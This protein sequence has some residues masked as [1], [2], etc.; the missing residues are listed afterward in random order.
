MDTVFHFFL[1]SSLILAPSAATVGQD[2]PDQQEERMRVEGHVQKKYI[3]KL[4]APQQKQYCQA[5]S[6][7]EYVQNN[8]VATVSGEIQNEDCAASSGTYTMNVRIRDENGELS[9]L[10]FEESWQREDDQPIK[11]EREYAIGNNVDLIRVRTRRMRC[12]CTEVQAEGDLEN[13]NQDDDQE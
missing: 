6:L 1:I 4:E 12:V 5:S 3:V 8:D 2:I 10:D 13:E 7:I 11:F 9:D